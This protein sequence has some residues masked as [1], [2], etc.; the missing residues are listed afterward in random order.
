[1]RLIT[2]NSARRIIFDYVKDLRKLGDELYPDNDKSYMDKQDRGLLM[3][4]EAI[5]RKLN[6][7]N[8]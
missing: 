6:G 2:L 4:G 8:K 5:A 7:V 3:F 1:M